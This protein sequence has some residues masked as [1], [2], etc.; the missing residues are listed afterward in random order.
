MRIFF[1]S[2]I[3][4]LKPLTIYKQ[5]CVYCKNN[6]F[7]FAN[8]VSATQKAFEGVGLP[9]P[10]SMKA[11]HM[12]GAINLMEDY[13][14]NKDEKVLFSPDEIRKGMSNYSSM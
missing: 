5:N 4:D 13:I 10:S 12:P 7:Y 14:V 3:L 9:I 1:F 11:G 2:C 8:S 6:R